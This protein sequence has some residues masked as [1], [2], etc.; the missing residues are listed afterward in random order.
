M[1]KETIAALE[2]WSEDIGDFLNDLAN[3]TNYDPNDVA[4]IKECHNLD[5]DTATDKELLIELYVDLHAMLE[6]FD[7][8][9]KKEIED[10]RR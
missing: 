7:E 5:P 10:E 3:F 1:K 9:I 6:R 8:I 2:W 4:Y